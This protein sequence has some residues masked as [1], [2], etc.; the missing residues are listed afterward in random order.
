[1]TTVNREAFLS[2]IAKDIAGLPEGARVGTASVRRLCRRARK[3]GYQRLALTD[4]DNLYG[5]WP[6]LSACRREGIVPI[7]GAEL[8]AVE[9]RRRAVCLVEDELG[10]A[11]LCRLI[12][13]R[14]T[15]DGFDLQDA[16]TGGAEG[17]TVY[18]ETYDREVYA[19]VHPAGK[20]RRYDWRLET[21]ERGA[22]ARGSKASTAEALGGIGERRLSNWEASHGRLRCQVEGPGSGEGTQHAPERRCP[23]CHRRARPERPEEGR[24]E[25]TG[26]RA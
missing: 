6:F 15:D 20:K 8:T 11:N 9:R 3:L 23:R 2:D 5:L 21:P 18:Q 26:Q 4:T 22:G 24:Q 13:R 12:T 19:E 25:G 17:L 14:H 16:V 10:Y 7:V 1:M